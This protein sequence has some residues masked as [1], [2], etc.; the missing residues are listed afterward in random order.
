MYYRQLDGAKWTRSILHTS[1][2]RLHNGHNK[3]N[4]KW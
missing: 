1:V 2:F 4:A 3:G